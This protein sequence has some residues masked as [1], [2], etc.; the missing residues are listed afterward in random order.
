MMS[1]VNFRFDITKATETACQFLKREGGSI[2][3][4]KLVKL[5]Y[6][7]DR[8]SVAKRGVPVVGGAYFSLPNGPITSE[9][10]D[11]INSGGLW[12]V[13]EC[14]WDEFLSARQNHE[15]ALIKEASRDH[16]ADSEMDLIEAIYQEHGKKNQWELVHWCHEHCDEWTPLEQGRERIAVDRIA[17][18]V[19]KTDEQIERLKEQTEEL[20]FLATAFAN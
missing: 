1:S 16:L 3:I 10:L 12:G 8:L 18:A 15:V 13:K 9:F 4:M 7:L 2:N 19:G 5:V 6:L 11:L 20:H 17:R 14:H